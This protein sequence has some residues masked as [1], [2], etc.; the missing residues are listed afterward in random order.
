ML[1]NTEGYE[2][3]PQNYIN[4]YIQDPTGIIY[5]CDGQQLYELKGNAASKFTVDIITRDG[6]KRYSTSVGD[7][8]YSTE[9]GLNDRQLLN[10]SEGDY[11]VFAQQE[12]NYGWVRPS[13]KII[14]A[15]TGISTSRDIAGVVDTTTIGLTQDTRERLIPS[16][17]GLDPLYKYHL[18]LPESDKPSSVFWE[19]TKSTS[20]GTGLVEEP[21]NPSEQT[22]KIGLS[23][24]DLD[25]TQPNTKVYAKNTD[26]NTFGWVSLPSQ[27][28]TSVQAGSGINVSGNTIS[29]TSD[30]VNRSISSANS[31]MYVMARGG[32]SMSDPIGWS[33]V[34]IPRGVNPGTGLASSADDIDADTLSL[35]QDVQDKLARIPDLPSA[36]GNY[37]LTCTI[38]GGVPT[39]AWTLA[40]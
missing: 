37:A 19:K 3:I 4:K 32:S 13:A 1:T 23:S 5:F 29:L 11:S 35:S 20:I 39:F 9:I 36:D 30:S 24:S 38:S 2:F 34:S 16:T 26:S 8:S 40:N 15:G 7:T 25:Y 14:K 18:V 17:D 33:S 27:S 6:L 31:G 10:A 21:T 28:G 12:G 22:L